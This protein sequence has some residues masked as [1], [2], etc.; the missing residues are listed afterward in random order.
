MLNYFPTKQGIYLELIP[1]SILTGESL[2]YKKN[3][4][5]QPVHYCQVHENE[6]SS[7]SDKVRTRGAICLGPCGNLQGGFKFMSLK[8]GHKI[9]RYNWGEIHI[10]QTVINRVN[11]IGKDKPEHLSLPI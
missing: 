7:N 4:T 9:T 5:L 11:V 10:P 3:L 8:T 2:N 6:G 1:S